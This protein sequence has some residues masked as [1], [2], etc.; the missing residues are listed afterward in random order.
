[1][2][3]QRRHFIQA[4]VTGGLSYAMGPMSSSVY[5]QSS[6][7]SGYK[8][9][10][11]VFLAG[12]NDSW[13]TVVP[14]STPEY[15]A[16][17]ASRGG[18][19]NNGL[20]IASSQLLPM[21]GN[22]DG[23]NYGFH[24]RMP[25]IQSLYNS[26]DCAVIAN[27]GPLVEPTTVRQFRDQ[28]VGVPPQLFSHNDQQ[29]QWHTLRGESLMTSGWGGRVA[30]VLSSQLGGQSL[31][32]NISLSGTTL[33]QAGN[34]SV[35][36]VMGATGSRPFTGLTP[37]EPLSDT[38]RSIANANYQNIYQRSFAGVQQRAFEFSDR[39]NTSL[40]NSHSFNALPDENIAS[41]LDDSDANPALVSQLRTVA[42]IISQRSAL[43]MSRQIFF[44]Q[45][46]GFDTHDNQNA[47]QQ[48]LLSNVSR[49]LNAFYEAMGEI[50][51][52]D[53]VTA[54][55][56]SD[57]G[58]TLSSNGDGADHGWGGVHLAVG[59]AV[60]GGQIY[61]QYPSLALGSELD[62]GRGRIVPTTSS[63]QYAATLANWFGV[64]NQNLAS[65]APS[66]NNFAQRDLGFMG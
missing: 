1:M 26:G 39:V 44:V 43:S 33:F 41:V 37:G 4:A 61:G 64:D 24:P 28:T 12:G 15:N 20:A 40:S 27:V 51:M 48:L 49:S 30:D 25:E 13:N 22:V 7:L 63:D 14:I 35:P 59:G 31:P 16:Y 42:K 47:E 9:L 8:A 62:L 65:I 66:I 57:F 60:N 50:N 34:S 17:N 55:T 36:Y 10:V 32:T 38:F 56:S 6:G 21:S 11:C 2:N 29:G 58:R 5:A 3:K 23:I 46:G 53:Q 54:Y 19:G 18:T 45:L 52:Q